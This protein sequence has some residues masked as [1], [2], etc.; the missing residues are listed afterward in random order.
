MLQHRVTGAAEQRSGAAT[1]GDQQ[2]P[3]EA[4]RMRQHRPYIDRPTAPEKPKKSPSIGIFHTPTPTKKVTFG[5]RYVACRLYI[6]QHLHVSNVP[7][8]PFVSIIDPL[9]VVCHFFVTL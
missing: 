8:L 1:K 3:Q 5:M 9:K 7:I 6:T 4:Q 2:L